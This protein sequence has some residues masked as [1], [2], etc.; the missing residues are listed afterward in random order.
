MGGD[1]GMA[2]GLLVMLGLLGLLAGCG[3]TVQTN[4]RID[5]PVKQ[6]E[7]LQ[8]SGLDT[9]EYHLR[10]CGRLL[11][12]AESETNAAD[13]AYHLECAEK[14]LDRVRRMTDE[15]DR[16]AQ[17]HFDAA[18]IAF[19]RENYSNAIVHLMH[20]S[21]SAQSNFD[22]VLLLGRSYAR[23]HSDPL[24]KEK[25][26]SNLNIAIEL[27]PQDPR[28]DYELARVHLETLAFDKSKFYFNRCYVKA[29][30]QFDVRMMS[31][32]SRLISEIVR[33]D[34]LMIKDPLARVI[35]IKPFL[36]RGEFAYLLTAMI[37]SETSSEVNDS[38]VQDISNHFY[39]ESI[40][41]TLRFGLLDSN[42]QN[43]FRPDDAVS[44]QEF[45]FAMLRLFQSQT[46]IVSLNQFA[47]EVP[48]PFMDIRNGSSVFPAAIFVVQN[49][50]LESINQNQADCF[51]PDGIVT[52]LQA[53]LAFDHLN[54][55][56]QLADQSEK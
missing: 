50:L 43:C 51:L 21:C 10:I 20:P 47:I 25:A 17:Y 9:P 27:R 37:S 46:G 36:K 8:P 13:R 44:R 14:S 26:V 29:E 3:K 34:H 15:K 1:V 55:M 6:S 30:S 4:I 23:F 7:R 32:T 49:H 48:S 39:Y 11:D 42:A 54:S 52:G 35:G 22:R 12:L 45:A 28:P 19:N 56:I 5:E 16:G 2:L 33:L 38:N 18:R 40:K 53:L 41:K 24:W 31:E